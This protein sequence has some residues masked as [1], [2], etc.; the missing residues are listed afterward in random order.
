WA[1]YDELRR[2]S[3]LFSDVIGEDAHL[4]SSTSQPVL[5]SF[6][7]LNYFDTLGPTM[8]L[9]RGLAA[10]DAGQNAAVLTDPAWTRLFS[11]DPAILDREIDLNGRMFRIVGVAG[12]E[13]GGL[14]DQPRDV[15]IERPAIDPARGG[16]TDA[17]AAT[18]I[19]VRLAAGVS[20]PQAEGALAGYM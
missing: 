17:S 5:A 10:I 8:A 9:G 20:V 7:S 6:V 3:D 18:M 1:D 14:G 19:I 11:R 2:R 4:V 12:R 13:F 15:F 16:G